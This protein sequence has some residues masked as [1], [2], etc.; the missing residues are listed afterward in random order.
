M[1]NG[2][3]LEQKH[4]F[5]TTTMSREAVRACWCHTCT[6]GALPGQPQESLLLEDE[7]APDEDAG[8][9][10]QAQADVEIVLP[11]VLT[12][13]EAGS[14]AVACHIYEHAMQM[15]TPGAAVA[16]PDT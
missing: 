12:H 10:G 2:E 7:A 15:L 14:V 9:D 8:A 13:R 3:C 6:H 5:T 4:G 1:T 16:G 11:S